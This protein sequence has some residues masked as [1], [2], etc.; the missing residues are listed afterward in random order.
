MKFWFTIIVITLTIVHCFGQHEQ[1]PR[2]F[3][4]TRQEYGAHHQNWS[5][6]QSAEGFLFFANTEGLLEFD[7]CSWKL[8]P[9]PEGQTVRT[10]VAGKE[11]KIFTGAYEE[12]GFWKRDALGNLT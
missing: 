7:G 2:L 12:F 4:F 10:V 3:H 6:A 9:L 8:H 5:A 1:V 11:G